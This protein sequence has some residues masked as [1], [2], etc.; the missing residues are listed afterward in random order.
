MKLKFKKKRAKSFEVIFR[1]L[2]NGSKLETHEL[3]FLIELVNLLRPKK[4]ENADRPS[5]RPLLDFL[6]ENE[7]QRNLLKDYIATLFYQRRFTLIL[8]DTGIIKDARFFGEIK[9]RIIAKILPEQ[10]QKDSLEYV[11]NQVLYIETDYIWIE[12]IPF[13]ELIE[14]AQVLDLKSIYNSVESNTPITEILNAMSLIIQRTSGRFLEKEVLQMIPE[15]ENVESPFEAFEK[16]LDV[17][18]KKVIGRENH[19]IRS[20]DSNY[21]KIQELYAECHGLIEKAFLNSTEFGISLRVNQSL[22]RIQQQ[23]NRLGVLLPFLVVDN[24]KDKGVNSLR[25]AMRLIRYNCK[26][27][28]VS[29]L[30]SE[31]T[32]T[33]SY[34]ITQHT[35]KTGEHYITQTKTEYFRMLLTAMG[36]GLI[37]GFMCVFKILLSGVEVSDFGHAFLYS[38]NYSLGF[39]VIYLLGF[40]LAT[41]QPAMTAAAIVKSIEAGM[42]KSINEKD[43]HLAFAELFSQLFRSQFIAFVGNVIIAFPVALGIVWLSVNLLDY[44]FVASKADKLLTDLSPVHSA[45]IFHAAIAGVFLFLSGIISG[46]V[47]NRNKYKRIY[48]RIAEHPV[49]KKSL[50][51][52]RTKNFAKWYDEKWPGVASNFWFGVFMGS[53][54]I[55]GV[56]LGLNLDIRHITFASGNLALGLFGADFEITPWMLF[57]GIFG[58]GIIGFVN[59]IVSFLLSLGLAFRSRDIQTSEIRYLFRSVWSYFKQ[60][61]LS[62]FIP[63]AIKPTNHEDTDNDGKGDFLNDLTNNS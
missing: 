42:Q 17:I 10:P 13:E 29:K 4:I 7:T 52:V 36:G 43:R 63:I 58:I 61:P 53:T 45:A 26:K 34:E 18:H 56:F 37:V 55:L 59:F 60:K 3:D 44:N 24:G 30:I 5:I 11:L 46:S 8:S 16:E 54:S 1:I 39:I 50:G 57:W 9:D 28:N 2:T 15:Y 23:L 31:S 25:L 35:A 40:T 47:S 41:K 33:I 49:L 19:S 22:L 12:S 38:L 21:I 27:N 62:F 14:F 32:Q 48:H 6:I 20:N 51:K